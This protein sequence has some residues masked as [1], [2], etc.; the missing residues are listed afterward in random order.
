MYH[1]DQDALTAFF[2]DVLSSLL[3]TIESG[4]TTW[5]EPLPLAEATAAVAAV[6]VTELLGLLAGLC[7][8]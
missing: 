6:A 7:T 2:K 4:L 5:L 8:L 3:T 1:N